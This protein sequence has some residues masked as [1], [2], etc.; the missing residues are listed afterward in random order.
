MLSK[1]KEYAVEMNWIKRFTLIELLVVIAII[2]ILAA[3]LLPALNR[4]RDTAQRT[5]CVGILKQYGTAAILYAGGNDDWWVPVASPTWYNNDPW[6]QLLG[7][8]STAETESNRYNV[9]M[10]CPKSRA[11]MSVIN[12]N[13][14]KV[15][16]LTYAYGVNYSGL[17]DGSWK[18]PAGYKLPQIPRPAYRMAWVDALD[19]LVYSYNEAKIMA[20]FTSGGEM[21]S[22]SSRMGLIAPRHLQGANGLFYDGHVE[23]P[24]YR[25]IIKNAGSWFTD[26]RKR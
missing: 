20:Y 2:A 4:A 24:G 14:L 7:V 25:E 16:M 10:I 6:R 19:H 21:I 23:S 12:T 15:G 11:A 5:V 22:E 3:M 26:P 8:N 1:R 13:S 17:H 9:S 18:K